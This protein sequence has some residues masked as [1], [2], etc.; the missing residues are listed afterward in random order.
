VVTTL[1]AKQLPAGAAVA[2]TCSAPKGKSG[3]AFKAKT[4]TFAKA[5]ASSAL[6]TLFKKRG[7]PAGTKIVVRITAPGRSGLALTYTTRKGKQPKR[8]SA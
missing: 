4:K 2:I 3:C 8:A 5:T 6:A 1:T 7:L